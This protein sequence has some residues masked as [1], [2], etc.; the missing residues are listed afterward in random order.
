[1][2]DSP[3]R[4]HSKPILTIPLAA[5]RYGVDPATIRAALRRSTLKDLPPIEPP[6]IDQ[7]TPVWYQRDFDHAWAQRPGKG[8]NLRG[9]K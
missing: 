5:E 3:L 8:A 1:M 2:A 7:R 6:P 9:H 4:W